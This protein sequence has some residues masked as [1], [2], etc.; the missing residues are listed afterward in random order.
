MLDSL[1]CPQD[2]NT[3]VFVGHAQTLA[4]TAFA[5]EGV[6]ALLPSVGLAWTRAPRRR[7]AAVGI[8]QATVAYGFDQ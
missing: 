3:Q 2:R 6:L 5:S 4:F 8:P 7:A 1:A